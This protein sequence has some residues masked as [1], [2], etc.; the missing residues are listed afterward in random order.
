MPDGSPVPMPDRSPG[1]DDERP[2]SKTRRKNAM[3][4]LQDLGH[5]LTELG[6]DKLDA[7][8]LPE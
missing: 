3:H 4:A 7:L 2:P 6:N 1:A 8:R 5:R